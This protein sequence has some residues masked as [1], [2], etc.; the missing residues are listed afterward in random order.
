MHSVPGIAS[1]GMKGAFQATV[2]AESKKLQEVGNMYFNR[3]RDPA[4]W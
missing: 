2:L 4:D 1:N 3:S